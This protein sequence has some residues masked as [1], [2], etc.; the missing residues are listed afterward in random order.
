MI[1]LALKPLVK[2]GAAGFVME[3]MNVQYGKG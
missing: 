3:R 2:F 1:F